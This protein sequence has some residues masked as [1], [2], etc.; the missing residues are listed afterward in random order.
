MRLVSLLYYTVPLPT[1]TLSATHALILCS[2]S[3]VPLI[4]GSSKHSNHVLI[5]FVDQALVAAHADRILNFDS[6][7]L[8]LNSILMKAQVM[9]NTRRYGDVY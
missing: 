5:A 8:D 3:N 9:P 7:W 1:S 4:L 2:S 6:G